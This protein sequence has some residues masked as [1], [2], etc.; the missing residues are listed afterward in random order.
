M[1]KKSSIV[2]LDAH[3]GQSRQPTPSRVTDILLKSDERVLFLPQIY[4]VSH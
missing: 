4:T 3:K 1:N 2:F